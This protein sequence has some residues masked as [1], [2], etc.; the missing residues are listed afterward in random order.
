VELNLAK[1]LTEH[2][3]RDLAGLEGTPAGKALVKAVESFRDDT[4]EEYEL[5]GETSNVIRRDARCQIAKVSGLN[6]VLGLQKDAQMVVESS[7]KKEPT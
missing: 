6:W 4:R 3:L 7:E 5:R 2:E 1:V